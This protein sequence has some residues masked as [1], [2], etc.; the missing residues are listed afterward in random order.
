MVVASAIPLAML[1][2]LCMMCL[3]GVSGNPMSLGVTDFGLIV[4]GAVIIVEV[5]Q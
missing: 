2:A 1:F 4:D 5:I 3:F